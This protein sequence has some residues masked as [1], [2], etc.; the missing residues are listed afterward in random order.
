M[1]EHE[2]NEQRS[3]SSSVWSGMSSL[4]RILV[5]FSTFTS[6]FLRFEKPLEHF[7]GG[8]RIASSSLNYSP[9]SLRVCGVI[10]LVS[11]GPLSPQ[12]NNNN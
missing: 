6:Q 5:Q 12:H 8:R 7:Q 4:H 2:I 3:E 11:F 9:Q 10:Q 1:S